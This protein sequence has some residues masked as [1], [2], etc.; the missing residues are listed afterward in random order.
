[1]GVTCEEGIATTV[2]RHNPLESVANALVDVVATML[3]FVLADDVVDRDARAIAGVDQRRSFAN[4]AIDLLGFP[5]PTVGSD[6]ACPLVTCVDGAVLEIVGA[7]EDLSELVFSCR[8]DRGIRG[9]AFAHR[10]RN[11]VAIT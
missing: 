5:N 10:R 9:W 3:E 7:L 4:G 8:W 2:G 11:S 6:F 1:M